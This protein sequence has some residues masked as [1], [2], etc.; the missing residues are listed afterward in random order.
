LAELRGMHA[1]VPAGGGGRQVS[2]L[3]A[4]HIADRWGSHYSALMTYAN[5]LT[6]VPGPT[7]V[8]AV[9][10]QVRPT[11][12]GAVPRVF[13]KVRAALEAAAGTGLA[14]AARADPAVAAGVRA[15]LGLDEA[16]WLCVGAAPCPVEL[17]EFFDA[18]GLPICEVWGMSEA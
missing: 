12:F 10:A 1:A 15:K 6:C 9:V 14:D 17:L 8:M 13:E 5:T 7:Q 11:F 4:A 18:L 16:R 3:P 2:F